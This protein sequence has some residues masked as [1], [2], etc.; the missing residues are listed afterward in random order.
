MSAGSRRLAVVLCVALILTMVPQ[1]RSAPG[2]SWHGV[3]RDASGHAVADA[4]VVLRATSGDREYAAKTS[5]SG[6]FSFAEIAT[7]TYALQVARGGV[8]DAKAPASETGRYKE[9]ATWSAGTPLTIKEGEALVFSLELAAQE[10]VV[11][12]LSGS[13][14]S[15][16]QGSGGEHLSSGEVSSLPLNERDFSKLL[17]LAAGTMTDT[18]GAANFT[19]QFTVNGQR[20]VA[21]VFAMY[22]ADTSD[23]ELGGAT[24]SN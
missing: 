4:T 20:G 8:A 21:S 24:F 1:A 2:A 6:G 17:L 15:A 22:G 5:A 18:N 9:T 11:R 10:Q 19:Q 7:G 16:S 3:L 23:P 14:T 12:V 13:E